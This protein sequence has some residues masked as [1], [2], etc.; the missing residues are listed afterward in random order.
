LPRY[1][2]TM[3]L[4]APNGATS[5]PVL[6]GGQGPSEYLDDCFIIVPS[7]DISGWQYTTVVPHGRIEPRAK[8]ASVYSAGYCF[9]Y[10]G[11]TSASSP[12]SPEGLEVGPWDPAPLTI[13]GTV[14]VAR[15]DHSAVL[16]PDGDSWVVFGGSIF[17]DYV[18]LADVVVLDLSNAASKQLVWSAPSTRGFLPSARRLQSATVWNG[19]MIVFGGISGSSVLSDVYLL[20]LGGT[21]QWLWQLQDSV[22]SWPL[23]GHKAFMMGSQ[24][25]VVGG[26]TQGGAVTPAGPT[27]GVLVL[28]TADWNWR[29]QQISGVAP[30]TWYLPAAA[31]IS[32]DQIVYFGGSELEDGGAVSDSLY[33]LTGIGTC[34]LCVCVC[35]CVCV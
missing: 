7:S 8:H 19:Y 32:T 30:T 14:P 1:A 16:T 33:L 27:G 9:L 2:A 5:R 6:C 22:S 13:D 10:G 34:K 11:N 12:A 23:Y 29:L 20:N 24:L 18:D 3:A 35:V 28:D 21:A 25:V 26:L 4:Y 15:Y 17:E 31:A